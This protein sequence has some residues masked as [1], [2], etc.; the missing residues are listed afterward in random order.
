MSCALRLVLLL[1]V[2]IAG[3][4]S[5]ARADG[6]DERIAALNTKNFSDKIAAVEALAGAGDPRAVAV[7]EALSAG[8]L[9][10]R[11]DDG[12]VVVAQKE[13]KRYLL[14]DPLSGAALGD[15]AKKEI[16]KIR[17]N[18][19]LRTA[20]AAAL[21][22]LTLR[23]SDPAQRLAAARAVM[24]S[25][26]AD[27]APVLE[28]ALAEETDGAAR[29]AMVLALAAIRLTSDADA[30]RRIESASTL[31]SAGDPEVRSLL[32]SRI[33]KN[34]DGAFAE[35][36]EAVRAAVDQALK[37]IESRLEFWTIIGNL[38]QG[39]SLGSVLLLAAIGLAITFGVMGVINMAHGEMVML[40]A[41]TTFAVQEVFRAHFPAAF[42]WS[43]FVA[44]PAAFL[45]AGLV[46]IAIERG[47][48]RSIQTPG[49][50]DPRPHGHHAAGAAD[51]SS[52]AA[53]RHR[54]RP[55]SGR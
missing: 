10:A 40:G 35:T 42:D 23:N 50:R 18:N 32:L 9:Y 46:G 36:D 28:A 37:R 38:F 7:L 16:K 54:R 20:I 11:K 12:A 1:L 47:I 34:K 51:R 43:L 30:A 3:A 41:Y 17:V 2:L 55:P 15:V 14:S 21:G 45:V 48:I 52:A 27:L 8:K 39:L 49:A 25:R 5:G 19:K 4:A 53:F 22:G 31:A 44:I 13:G 6:I 29:D 24:K 33:T 26:D